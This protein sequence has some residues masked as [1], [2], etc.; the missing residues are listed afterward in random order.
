[1]T[2]H[3]IKKGHTELVSPSSKKGTAAISSG[4]RVPSDVTEDEVELLM[5]LRLWGNILLLQRPRTNFKE[6]K[7]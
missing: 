5:N 1:M 6:K 7:V 3:T 4:V 2:E